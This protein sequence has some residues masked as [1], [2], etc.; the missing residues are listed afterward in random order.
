M[1][2]LLT[3]A[4][5]S[6]AATSPVVSA[7]APGATV[8]DESVSTSMIPPEC[9][10]GAGKPVPWLEGLPDEEKKW[11]LSQRWYTDWLV[12]TTTLCS[13]I[14]HLPQDN[15]PPHQIKNLR[16]VQWR[17]DNLFI[18][19][20]IGN[21]THG[22]PAYVFKN[23]FPPFDQGLDGSLKLQPG[24]NVKDS[25][26]SS[27][28]YSEMYSEGFR[29]PW[30]YVVD[31]PGGILAERTLHKEQTPAA[32]FNEYEVTF[33]GGVIAKYVR[34]VFNKTSM[35][36][37]PNPDYQGSQ[38][39]P[40]KEHFDIVLSRVS[41]G[42]SLTVEPP[43]E[44]VDAMGS[45]L[46]FSTKQRLVKASLPVASQSAEKLL[47]SWGGPGGPVLRNTFSSCFVSSGPGQHRFQVIDA[48]LAYN[49]SVV[50]GNT[51]A[52]SRWFILPGLSFEAGA[53]GSPS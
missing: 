44:K 17:D 6:V 35:E 16:E 27:T 15:V 11:I 7:R 43:G 9:V 23:G 34:G 41:A 42:V 4:L 33:P 40:D 36:Y 47:S 48:A 1:R 2:C 21:G 51:T 19:R 3:L 18:C 45:V 50:Q 26:V 28:A 20:G 8:E 10:P 30:V 5:A 24:I 53:S 46:R 22:Q 31:A 37:S 12:T 29:H 49:S 32:T 14:A 13:N 39:L 25:T 38:T 52:A